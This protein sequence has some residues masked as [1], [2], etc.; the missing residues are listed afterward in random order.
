MLVAAFAP[1]VAGAL[2]ALALHG[3]HR[4]FLVYAGAG[5]REVLPPESA[6]GPPRPTRGGPPPPR[7]LSAPPSLQLVPG[8]EG[9]DPGKLAGLLSP[10]EIYDQEPRHEPWAAPVEA[11]I[12]K[13]VASNMGSI[14]DM[15]IRSVE[16]KTT[17]CKVLWDAPEGRYGQIA[18][19]MKFVLIGS[20]MGD[21]PKGLSGWPY[22]ICLKGGDYF[23]DVPLNDPE[24]TIARIQSV[25]RKFIGMYEQGRL[26]GVD[27]GVDL[28]QSLR[29]G[30]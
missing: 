1:F 2:L 6:A 27:P 5:N 17:C 12:T 4:Q 18:N 9:Y 16:C 19:I 28:P 25:R 20:K 7:L 26:R 15:I 22:Y 13:D 14:E 21:G 29:R 8:Q 10:I 30:R 11:F 3:P 23:G 24:A